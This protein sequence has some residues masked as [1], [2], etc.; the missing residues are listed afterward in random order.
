GARRESTYV[1]LPSDHRVAAVRVPPALVGRSL[2]AA[3]FRETFGATVLMVARSDATGKETRFI[4][5]G[6]TTFAA[7]DRL[8][9]FGAQDKLEAL[10]RGSAS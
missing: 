1:E 6:G 8:I 5:E 7:G 9:V 2:A 3:R 10:E 4:P